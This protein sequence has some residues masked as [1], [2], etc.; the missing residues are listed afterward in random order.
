MNVAIASDHQG[1]NQKQKITKYLIKKGYKVI[2][3]G[4]PT[5]E[6]TDFPP[7]AFKVCDNVVSKKADYG[8][9]ICGTGIGMSIAAN[10]VKGIRC[11]KIN[12]FYEAKYAKRHNNANVI[13]L[14]RRTI[15]AKY[16]ALTFLK[17][18]FSKKERYQ[19]RNDMITKYEDT[20][21]Y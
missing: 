19:K 3:F 5:K 11:A 10:K 7:L 8:I 20:N 18:N 13:N 1:F 16:M 9:L 15:F 12:N 4:I 14:S 6:P 2:D 17:A 21:E